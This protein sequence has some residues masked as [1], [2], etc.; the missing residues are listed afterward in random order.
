[1]CQM[2]VSNTVLLTSDLQECILWEKC[3]MFTGKNAAQ[4]IWGI[5]T[6]KEN[7]IRRNYQELCCHNVKE[8]NCL[9]LFICLKCIQLILETVFPKRH[10]PELGLIT[11]DARRKKRLFLYLC[12]GNSKREREG[13]KERRW[14]EPPRAVTEIYPPEHISKFTHLKCYTEVF[15]QINAH[16]KTQNIFPYSYTYLSWYYAL[17]YARIRLKNSFSFDYRS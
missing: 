1:M 17:I 10:L 2:P 12:P 16:L 9:L 6:K 3:V 7:I 11:S 14:E 13:E 15:A 5:D 8:K 4:N